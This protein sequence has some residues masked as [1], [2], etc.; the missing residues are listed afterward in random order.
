MNTTQSGITTRHT[1]L[2][3]GVSAAT[4]DAWSRYFATP[5]EFLAG[6]HH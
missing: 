2:F 1:K 4:S 3:S 5:L 6:E